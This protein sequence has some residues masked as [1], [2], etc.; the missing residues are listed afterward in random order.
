MARKKTFTQEELYQAAHDLMLEVGYDSFSFQALS[1]KI[2]VSR[3]ALYKY[4]ANKADLLQSYL[5]HQLNKVV[6]RMDATNWS[7]NYSDKLSELMDLVFDYAETH[8]ISM[9]VP[10]RKWSNDNAQEPEIIR[11]KELH[12]RFFGYIQAIIEEGQT[13]GYLKKD[14]PSLIIIETIFHSINLPNRTGLTAEEHGFFV[15][16]LLFEGIIK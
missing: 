9:E 14:I 3:T 4:Y 6:E 15:K 10:L 8:T 11:S 13:I 2:D 5:D 1:K 16:K 7:S 12:A